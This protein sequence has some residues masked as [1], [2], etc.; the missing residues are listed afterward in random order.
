MLHGYQVSQALYVAA[1]LGIADLLA[2]GPRSAEELAGQVGAH[3]PTLHRL[4][5]LLASLGVFAEDDAGH[6]G[7]TPLAECLRSDAPGSQ[8]DWAIMVCGPSFWASWGDLLTSV[9]TGEVAF[10]RVHGMDRWNYLARHP[11]EGA[12]FDAAMTANTALESEAVV[13]G[14]DFSAFGVVADVGGGAGGLLATLLAAHPSMRGI[15][16]DRLQVVAV[17]PALLA[18]AGVAERCEVVGGDFFESVPEGADA[19]VLKSVIHDWEDEQG[20]AILR[21]CR[22]AMADRATLLLVERVIR[23]GNAPDPAKFMDLLMLVMN[24]GRERTADDF[25]RL[26][27][28]AGFRLANVTSTASPLSIIEARPTQ[29]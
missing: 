17:A 19:Y 22:S 6:F 27:A 20:V 18:R 13:G 25:A 5:R 24:G 28:A 15:L 11:E 26:L 12:V 7:L 23:P 9:R 8:R 2:G 21:T 29:A 10:P 16:F 3:G 4:L 1:T 14:Y